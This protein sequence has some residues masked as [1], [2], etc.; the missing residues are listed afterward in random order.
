MGEKNPRIRWNLYPAK[1]DKDRI[2]AAA[3]RAGKP[4]SLFL[5]DLAEYAEQRE[6]TERQRHELHA[7]TEPLPVDVVNDSGDKVRDGQLVRSHVG[8][9]LSVPDA[10]ERVRRE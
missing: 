8:S 6:T 4:A 10:T 1:Q 5:A 3:K 7:R 9:R 2:E